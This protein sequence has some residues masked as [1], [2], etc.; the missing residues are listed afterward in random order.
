MLDKIIKLSLKYRL[1]ILI[2]SAITLIYGIRVAINLPVDVFPDLNRPLVTIMTDAHGLAAEEVETLVTLPIEATLSGTPGVVRIRSSSAIGISIV[3][4]EFEWGTDLYKNRQYVAERLQLSRAQIPQGLVPIM[5]PSSSI[6]GEIM[7]VGLTSPNKEVDAMKLRE[8]ADWVV[9]PRLMTVSGVSQV[10]VMGGDLKQYQILV[11]S[12]KLQS[13]GITLEDFKHALS[14]ISENTTGGFVNVDTKEYLI[15]PLGRAQSISDLEHSYVGTH[16]GKPVLL[17]DVAKI[18]LG[19]AT[20]R[21][22]SSVNGEHAVVMTVQ[23]Q[24]SGDSIKITDLVVKELAEIQKSLP[25][26]VEIEDNL[27]RQANFIENSIANVNEALRDGAIMVAIVLFLFL[28][29]VRTTMITLT[30]IPLS[31]AVTA[32]VFHFF[33]L[34]VNTMTLGGLAVAIGELVDDAIVDVENVFRRLRENRAKGNPVSSLKIVYLASSEIR[35]SIVF[36]TAIVVLVFVPLFALSGIEGR[37]FAPLGIAYI[38]SLV[39]S[40][41]VSLT[42]TPV[43]CSYLLPKSKA[44]EEKDDGFLVRFLKARVHKIVTLVLPYPKTV[45]LSS[46]TILA[47]CLM[48]LPLMGRNFLPEFNEGSATIGIASMP[49][50]SLPYNDELGLKIERELLKIPETKSTVRRLGRA[51]NDEHAEGVHWNEIE[52]DFKEEGRPR[53]EVLK[54]IRSTISKVSDEVT[55]NLGQP[56]SHRLDHLLSGVRAQI[57]LK[58]FGPDMSELRRIAGEI[59][60]EIEDIEGLVDLAVEPAVLVPQ[61]K[62]ILDRKEAAN[63]RMGVGTLA[64]DLEDMLN[65]HVV[66]QFLDEQRTFD[67]LLRLDEKS[68]NTPEIIKEIPIRLLP[69]G[70]MLK[71]SDVAEVYQGS[72]P[73]A[74]NREDMVRRV[75]VSANSSGRDLGAL[76]K[77]IQDRIEAIDVP[78]G[79]FIKLGGQ[80]ENQQHASRLIAILGTISLIGIFAVLFMHFKSSMLSF[81]VMLNIPMALIGSILAVYFSERVLSVATLIAFITLCG[82]ASRN[83]IMMLTHYL[84]LMKEEGEEFTKEMVIRGTL[85]RLV[86]VLMTAL[87]AVLALTPLVLS[88]GEPG[89]EILH[90]VA[91][92]IVGGLFSSTLLDFL[93]TPVIFY[94]YGKKSALKW[95]KHE[96]QK[97]EVDL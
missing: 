28:L 30:A 18:S 67:I 94:N 53:D 34:G 60:F 68:R 42:L 52:L 71:L 44:M 65:G 32:I 82:I 49:G 58:V 19:A 38:I 50:L 76:V 81:Q 90:P 47:A 87:T 57:A 12:E 96:T 39:A 97:H 80:F 6:M 62:M 35:N 14:E 86:P 92:V 9:R 91:V 77:D 8:L 23:K 24:P 25:H 73:N 17:K 40:L 56:I 75:V 31:F 95:L 26:G 36:S 63:A 61:L 11:S 64:Q 74:I 72:G 84:H 3:Y 7:F 69:D 43:L 16:L 22:Q 20:K 85:E 79:Y 4:V 78:Q 37:L 54:E 70:Q 93:V 83:G 41:F 33:G 2:L 59:A 10:I 27:F 88:K 89:K 55:M 29:N 46:I 21:G 48:L 5:S 1:S 51:E 66:G 45:I 13:K 15:R